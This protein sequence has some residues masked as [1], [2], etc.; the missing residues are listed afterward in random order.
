MSQL[1]TSSDGMPL[2]LQSEAPCSR[3]SAG[4]LNRRPKRAVLLA[5]GAGLAALAIAGAAIAR[6]SHSNP[7]LLSWIS[8]TCCVTN[9]CCWEIS[10]RDLKPLAGDRWQVLSTGEVRQRTDWSPDGKF[11]R[12]A[13]DYDVTAKHWI[14]HQAANTRCLFVPMR[15]AGR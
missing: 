6:D 11:Y 9:D 15:T 4:G 1:T 10:E 12:C 5:A 7:W 13:C 2:A 3:A 14:R 8:P